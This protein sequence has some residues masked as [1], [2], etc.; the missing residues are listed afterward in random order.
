[1]DSVWVLK[2]EGQIGPLDEDEI[3]EMLQSGEIS[4]SDMAVC[5]PDPDPKPLEQILKQHSVPV[6]QRMGIES[7]MERLDR[8]VAV[9]KALRSMT[10]IKKASNEIYAWFK[11]AGVKKHSSWAREDLKAIDVARDLSAKDA[12]EELVFIVVREDDKYT[13][14]TLT[15]SGAQSAQKKTG[16]FVAT[17]AYGSPLATEVVLLSHFRDEILLSS[18]LGKLFVAFYYRVSPP[19]ALL[20]TKADF[21]RAGTRTLLLTPILHLIKIWKFRK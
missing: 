6:A 7:E 21:L 11:E 17:A 12:R 5:Y 19:I 15:E 9:E 1:M 20:I 16:C 14:Y 2:D 13:F 3:Q 4:L 18:K 10:E 8:G